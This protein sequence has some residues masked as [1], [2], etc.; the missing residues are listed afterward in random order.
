MAKSLTI[1][2][3]AL[4]WSECHKVNALKKSMFTNNNKKEI[5]RNTSQIKQNEP[6]MMNMLE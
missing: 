3:L 5:M 1:I 6:E 4:H 2:Y